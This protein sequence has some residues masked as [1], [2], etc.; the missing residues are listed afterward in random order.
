ASP[1]RGILRRVNTF[2]SFRYRDFRYAFTGSLLSNIGTWMQTMALGWVVFDLTGSSQA[3]GFMNALAGL[4]VMVLSIFAGALADR[5]DRRKML[6]AVQALLLV[7]A[8]MFGVLNQTG[9]ITMAWIYALSLAGGVASAFMSPS[10]QAMTPDLVPRESLMNAIALNSAQFNA[11]RLVGPMVGGLVFAT[12]GVTEVFYVNAASFLFV[13]WALSVIRPRQTVHR[14]DDESAWSIMAGGLTYART[15]SRVAWL[16]TSAAMLTTFGTPYTALMPAL[17]KNTLG[18]SE[19]GYSMLLAANGLG[20]LT[21]ALLVASYSKTI[22]RERI[23]RSGYVVMGAADVG[24]ALSRSVPLTVGLLVVL[25]AAFLAIISS[26]NTTLQVYVPS[27]IRGR[28]MALYVL[29]FLG[30]MPVGAA[31]F[32]TLGERLGTPTAIAIGGAVTLAF[33]ALLLLR[34]GLLCDEGQRC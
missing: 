19:T 24:L 10:W 33:G 34:P 20:A 22:R 32:G 5:V 17:A 25:G 1:P 14:H 11:A 3:L 30:M 16:L 29:A 21:S 27:E 26:V 15:H 8:V 18:L 28:V 2:E 7:Q 13:I 12:L 23:I 6:I 31:L 9:H 4:P